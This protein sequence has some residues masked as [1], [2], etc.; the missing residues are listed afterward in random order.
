[1]ANVILQPASDRA[2]SRP[3]YIDTIINPIPLNRMTPHISASQQEEITS[4]IP[5]DQVSTWGIKPSMIRQWEKIESGDTVLFAWDN[6]YRSMSTVLTKIRNQALA[7]E[8]WGTDNAGNTWELVYFL[9]TPL[10]IAVPYTDLNAVG[11][12]KPNYVPQGVNVIQ[13]EKAERILDVVLGRLPSQTIS[14][15]IQSVDG[16]QNLDRVSTSVSRGEQGVLRNSLLQ[17]SVS[18]VCGICGYDYPVSFLIAAHIKKRSKCTDDEKRDIPHIAMPMCLMGCDALYEAGY[19][20]VENGLIKTSLS[21]NASLQSKLNILSD[22]PCPY[23]NPEREKYFSWH[24][25]N[26]FNS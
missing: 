9:Q 10:D 19:V 18:G 22:N 1:M 17:S 3:H 25:R 6:H 8:L 24:R 21:S 2:Y 20:T 13:G 7:N 15:V 16:I 14:Q 5:T 4:V 23:W 11:S 12:F 26:T